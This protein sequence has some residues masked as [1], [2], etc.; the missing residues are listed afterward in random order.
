MSSVSLM[1]GALWRRAHTANSWQFRMA[2]SESLLSGSKKRRHHLED[3]SGVQAPFW[4]NIFSIYFALH[5]HRSL[6][7]GL[8]VQSVARSSGFSHGAVCKLDFSARNLRC[9]NGGIFL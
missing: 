6:K 1:R 5:D 8:P 7:F 2:I 4:Y 9:G 3:Q